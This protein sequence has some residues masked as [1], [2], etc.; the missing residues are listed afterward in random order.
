VF[1]VNWFRKSPEGK[2]L[3]PGYGD[4]IRVLKWIFERTDD[5]KNY[6]EIPFGLI[7][8]KSALDLDGLKISDSVLNELFSVT[9]EQVRNEVKEIRSYYAK[10]G[11]HLPAELLEEAKR[12]EERAG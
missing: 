4:N 6:T 3:W 1:Y 7:P 2:F 11:D 5:V 10:F 9:G 8:T 12:L